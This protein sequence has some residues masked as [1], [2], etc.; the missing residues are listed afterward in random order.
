MKIPILKK[1]EKKEAR[2]S[3]IL[4]RTKIK[5]KKIQYY[6]KIDNKKITII[7]SPPTRHI[8]ERERAFS[9]HFIHIYSNLYT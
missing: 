1:K 6:T 3:K 5:R 7:N 9:F 4:K 8:E 2:K